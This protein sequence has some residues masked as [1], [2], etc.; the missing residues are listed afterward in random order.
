MPRSSSSM[1][2]ESAASLAPAPARYEPNSRL[3]KP[4]FFAGVFTTASIVVSAVAT[5]TEP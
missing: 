2:F 1:R 5:A 3:R 4:P